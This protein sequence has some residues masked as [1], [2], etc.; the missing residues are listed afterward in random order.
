MLYL[1][2]M[3]KIFLIIF[4]GTLLLPTISL[5]YNVFQTEGGENIIYKGIVPCGKPVNLGGELSDG[6]IADG[7]CCIM[8]CTFCH[9]FVMLDGAI[10]FILFK[11]IPPIAILMLVIGGVMFMFAHFGGAEALPGGVSG[12][13]KMLSQAKRLITSVIIGLIIIFAAWIIIDL[14]FSLIGVA[15][16][17]GLQEGWFTINCPTNAQVCES[18]LPEASCMGVRADGKIPCA[19]VHHNGTPVEASECL[20]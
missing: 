13:P 7:T 14:F 17:T 1:T 18:R 20:E 12:G 6:E 11:L 5:A 10:D 2:N 16:W 3:K 19:T 4:L 15:E 9:V 8:P